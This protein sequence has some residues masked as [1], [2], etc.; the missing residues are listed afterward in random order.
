MKLGDAGSKCTDGY[1]N[2]DGL[3]SPVEKSEKVSGGGSLENSQNETATNSSGINEKTYG[4][5]LI[6]LVSVIH[7]MF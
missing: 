7:T 1:E 3:C 6:F 2:D 4:I 5:S